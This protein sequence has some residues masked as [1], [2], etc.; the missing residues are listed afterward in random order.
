MIDAEEHTLE[1]PEAADCDNV[2]EVTY[3]DFSED[4]PDFEREYPGDDVR[5]QL[6]RPILDQEGKPQFL[7]S[8]GCPI[9]HDDPR[10]CADWNPP[11]PVIES[12]ESFAQWYRTVPG[13]NHEFQ[14]E[15]VL[16]ETPPG[17]GVYVYES[18]AF[19]PLGIDEGFGLT[20]RQNNHRG[21][22]YFFTT[23]IH[24]TFT[25]QAGQ[26]FTFRGDDDLWI[27]VNDE[28]ALDLGSMHRAWE[29]SIDFD[30]LA[31]ELQIS[32]GGVYRMDVFHAE[33]HTYDSNFRI[34]TNISCFRPAPPRIAR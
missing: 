23:E 24:L 15:L 1:P 13:V 2:L 34:E 25:Y 19:F 27:F 5:L 4:H 7:S 22:N 16:T 29:G 31:S 14:K 30:A 10:V 8:V 28:L 21:V 33:R 11:Q 26:I 18:D 3:R 12:A 32:P 20:P 17:S 9:S 6:I